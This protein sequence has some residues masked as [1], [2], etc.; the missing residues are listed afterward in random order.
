MLQLSIY[1][2]S[3]DYDI[4]YQTVNFLGNEK[5]DVCKSSIDINTLFNITMRRFDMDK[6][7]MNNLAI[8]TDFS[9]VSDYQER[10]T[11]ASLIL[12]SIDMNFSDKID[13]E[14][15]LI[16]YFLVA[17]DSSCYKI[18]DFD[19]IISNID[20]IKTKVKEKLMNN[21][22]KYR[23]QMEAEEKDQKNLEITVDDISKYSSNVLSYVKTSY[24]GYNLSKVMNKYI[25]D[26]EDTIQEGI[27]KSILDARME[28]AD[29]TVKNELDLINKIML[30]HGL[31][32]NN[33]DAEVKKCI[34]NGEEI[35]INKLVS[36]LYSYTFPEYITQVNIQDTME[37]TYEIQM[38]GYTLKRAKGGKISITKN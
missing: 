25:D 23:D 11:I 1:C 26:N 15:F 35:D 32:A 34:Y 2:F 30:D 4:K 7:K 5:S 12:N 16:Q 31:N 33:K 18:V 20:S 28:D 22:E 8:F 17:P 14:K 36:L 21:Y 24:L 19:K 3:D 29:N 6:S 9:V 13:K 38:N 37:D 10:R 27:N